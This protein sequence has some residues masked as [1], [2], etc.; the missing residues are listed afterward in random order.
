MKK[1]LWRLEFALIFIVSFFIAIL[2]LGIARGAGGFVGGL[3]YSLWRSRRLIALENLKRAVG[4]GSLSISKTPEETVKEGFKNLGRSFAEVIKAYRGLGGGILEQIKIEG[5]ENLQKARAKARGV[6]F[7]TAHGGNWE[8]LALGLS[9]VAGGIGVVAR[10]LK[11]PYL[12]GM[13]E[14]VRGA[15]GNSVIYK[16]GALKKIISTLRA[17]GNVGILM[18]QAVLADE[19]FLMD[20]LGSPAWT[21]KMPALIAKKTDAAV[22][23]TFIRRTPD[24]HEIRIYPEVDITGDEVE[25]TKKISSFIENYIRENPSEWLWMHRRWKRAS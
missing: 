6:I 9:L 24:G 1:A 23:P 17:G 18:D 5:G 10:P 14:K 22:V 16:K 2:P 15:S 25:D 13:L 7:I 3:A 4:R 21:T 8:L 19:G 20:F 12:N 11:N